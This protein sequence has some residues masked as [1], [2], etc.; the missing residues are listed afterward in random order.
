M[1]CKPKY[2]QNIIVGVI[3]KQKFSWYLTER[4]YWI[5]DINKR[6]DDYLKN[7]YKFNIEDIIEYRFNIEIVS[8]DTVAEYLDNLKEYKVDAMVLKNIILEKTYEDTILSLMPSLFID[9][10]KRLLFSSYP[11]TLEFERYVPDGWSGNY[12]DLIEYVPVNNRYWIENETDLLNEIYQQEVK[13]FM[14]E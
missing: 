7:G 10:D 2:A 11:E 4:D 1:I 14:E 13:E 9:F 5:L 6:R 3:Y 8:Q 12:D